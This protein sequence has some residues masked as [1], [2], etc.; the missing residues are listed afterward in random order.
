MDTKLSVEEAWH[1]LQME[2]TRQ[3]ALD[4][5]AVLLL[6]GQIEHGDLEE[7]MDSINFCFYTP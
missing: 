3:D 4:L 1:L 2:L 7:L 6:C 5:L